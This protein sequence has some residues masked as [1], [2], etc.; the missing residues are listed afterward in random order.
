MTD[1]NL[2]AWA[3]TQ[4]YDPA[5]DYTAAETLP[6]GYVSPHFRETEFACKHC[7][8][9][10]DT[11]IPQELIDVL[12]MVREHYN[13]P[14]TINSGYRCPTHNK[15]VGGVPNSQHLLG[16]AADI[17]V[18]GVDPAKVYA[19]LDPYH[20]GGLGKYATFTHIDVRGSRARWSG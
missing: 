18:K 7:G 16:T 11:G 6:P 2:E 10:A 4:G 8:K 12:E 15:E 5:K 1:A 14:V 13:A 17:V 20:E 19:A 3:K 9:L